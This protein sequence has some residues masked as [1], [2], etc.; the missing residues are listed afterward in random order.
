[1]AW[2]HSVKAIYRRYIRN[3]PVIEMLNNADTAE[4]EDKEGRDIGGRP[5][6]EA[7]HT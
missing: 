7:F 6:G 2:R 1:M 4:G 3:K 5:V